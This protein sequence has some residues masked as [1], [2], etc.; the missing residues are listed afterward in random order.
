[1]K[2]RF[3]FSLLTVTV[4]CTV[5][6]SAFGAESIDY[7]SFPDKE[8]PLHDGHLGNSRYS[9]LKGIDTG[10]VKA[11]GGVWATE[12]KGGISRSSP[13]VQNGL[14]FIGAG[15]ALL[16]ANV[17]F[18]A[19]EG[20]GS[21][22]LYALNPKTGEVVWT[23]VA[24]GA[25][26]SNLNKGPGAGDGKVFLGLAD[27]HVVA[28]DQKTGKELWNTLAGAD[29]LPSGEF[30][31][32]APIYAAGLVIVG[33]GSG[34]AGISGR[35]VALD[36]KT[37]AKRWEFRTIPG[38]HEVGHD[39]WPS[40]NESWK[41]GG[42]GIWANVS[43]DPKLGLVYFGTG[44]AFPMLGG[45]VRSGD[46][47]YTTSLVAID[48]KTG[49]YRWH[50]QFTH[51]DMWESDVGAPTVLYDA[52]VGGKK[53]P[54]IAAMRTD[55]N[56]LTFNRATGAPLQEMEERPVRQVDRLHSS[57]TQPYPKGADQVGFACA[58]PDLTPVGFKLGCFYDAVDYTD[59]NMM[60]PTSATR[61]A[62]MSYD[63]ETKQF[64]ITGAVGAGWTRRA[65][66]P[67]F[68][69]G[70]ITPVPG[71][72]S[73]GVLAA[74]DAATHKITWQKKMPSAAINNG[75]GAMTTAGGLLFHG[76]PDGNLQ[77]YD[78]K[79]GDLLWQFQT[80]EPIGGPVSTYELGGQQYVAVVS[81]S[82]VWAF[83]IG[84]K[85]DQATARPVMV[86]GSG[87]SG[88][89]VPTNK[90][91]MGE[92]QDSL[93]GPSIKEKFKDDYALVPRRAKVSVGTAVT[94]T[95]TSTLTRDATAQDGSWTTGPI[96]PGQSATVTVNKPGSY[97]YV[98]KAHPWVYGEL[99]VE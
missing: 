19:I 28:V 55:G 82:H 17:K 7:Q 86:Q 94:W 62:P 49:K 71:V 90:I 40:D 92:E 64:Y 80:G 46:N 26:V 36:A 48:L 53:V 33:I 47:L 5:A 87:F 35:V 14:M 75:S 37:G 72:K 3:L 83:A 84:G 59:P 29:P 54:A 66:N 56:L 15:G 98:S 45:E 41:Q 74:F 69:S 52:M 12:L 21:G 50:Y 95:N 79:N 6:A 25:G 63:P 10:T 67:Y 18:M 57:K 23:Y 70:G 30:I 31:G 27:A 77:A 39:S 85:L 24:P 22:G 61:S 76:E 16:A 68:F 60:L 91:Q 81:G 88:R 58:Q 20:G 34:D 89:I 8:W 73:Y 96:L 65:V 42:G 93:I 97:T 1:M 51:H 99:I 9:K 43:V 13:I 4:S 78:A 38:P 2:V 32:A 11:L 44:N